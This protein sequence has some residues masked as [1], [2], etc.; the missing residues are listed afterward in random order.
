MNRMIM[1]AVVTG[2]LALGGTANAATNT[3]Q[4]PPSAPPCVTGVMPA[5]GMMGG[6]GG[7]G[8]AMG[9]QRA[10]KGGRMRGGC[11][12]GGQFLKQALN[13]SDKQAARIDDLNRGHFQK[14]T[15]ERSEMF[16]LQ[17]EL[18]TESLQKRP[19]DQKIASLT[20]R[21]GSLH[22]Q[23]ASQ[24][25]AHLKEIATVLDSKQ[26]E[27]MRNMKQNRQFGRGRW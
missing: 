26:L 27:T 1:T 25:S 21:I 2:F 4:T 3:S 13:L 9:G 18:A 8:G 12:Q 7:P 16:R 24:K 15:Q 5:G 6:P 23:F 19:D 10:M 14:M 22:A 11:M 17:Q 20:A